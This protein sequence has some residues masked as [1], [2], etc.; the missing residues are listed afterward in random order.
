MQF[1]I[2][3][4]NSDEKQCS[5]LPEQNGRHFPD[6]IFKY[7]EQATSHCMNQS[8]FTQFTDAYMRH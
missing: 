7:A 5:S 2:K 1:Q 4:I 8:M 6:D 3:A